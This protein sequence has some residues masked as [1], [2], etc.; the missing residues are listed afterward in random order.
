MTQRRRV[1]VVGSSCEVLGHLLR[2]LIEQ[3]DEVESA[4]D[5]PAAL[6]LLSQWRP[7]LILLAPPLEHLDL[8]AFVAEQ[9]R[10]GYRGTISVVAL[11][12]DDA[13]EGRY[14]RQPSS[15]SG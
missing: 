3:G 12:A 10:R 14:G 7:D 11:G 15:R 5:G 13:L 9:R 8:P 2:R 4:F 6:A 1:L